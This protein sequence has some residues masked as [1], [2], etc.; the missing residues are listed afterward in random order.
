[1]TNVRAHPR[2][3]ESGRP[4]KD[5]SGVLVSSPRDRHLFSPGPK[6]ILALDGGGLRGIVSLAFLERCEALL[7]TRH[8]NANLVLSDYFDLIG[9]TST[10]AVIATGLALGY[11]VAK[12]IDIYQTLSRDGFQ[13]RY[14]MGGT[15]VPKF[16]T[17]ALLAVIRSQTGTEVLG[18]EKLLCG[19]GIVAKRLD[20]GSVWSFHNNPR[21]V[22]FAPD[23]SHT[24]AVPNRDLPLANLLRA[25][26]AAP[27]YF[28][29]ETLEVARGVKGAFVD[30]GVSPHNNPA[31]LMLMLATLKGYGFNWP[32]GGDRL[33]IMSV[34]TGAPARSRL[35]E[36]LSRMPA[37][38]LAVEALR[39][40][41]E[42]CSWLNQALLQW[43]GT[44]PTPWRIDGEVGDLGEDQIAG[45]PLLHYLR[46]DAPLVASW[47]E[48]TLGLRLAPAELTALQAIDRPELC[49][50]LLDIGR[51]AAE[52]QV[53]A[54]HF[55]LRFDRVEAASEGSG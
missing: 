12:L 22:F 4:K 49:V 1:V 38:L 10:G 55:P 20:T 28:E 16:R 48:A 47:L 3:D 27:T 42:D 54:E 5:M 43:M 15:L 46:Y 8:G 7:R 23:D 52:Q 26:T 24:T 36:A 40:M 25:S 51:R 53:R 30:G 35:P 44:S 41:M 45:Q 11:S 2:A 9:G 21:G 29:P 13:R 37:V 32:L 6:R 17:E 34:G 18:S 19:L 33:L 14:W 50:R 39:S 31:L